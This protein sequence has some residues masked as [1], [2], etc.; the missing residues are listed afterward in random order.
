MKRW[1]K[2]AGMTYQPRVA[3]ATGSMRAW[4]PILELRTWK[5]AEK[6]FPFLDSVIGSHASLGCCS[7]F[8]DG[9]DSSEGDDESVGVSGSMRMNRGESGG[10]KLASE[11]FRRA[12]SDLKYSASPTSPMFLMAM[13]YLVMIYIINSYEE[14]TVLWEEIEASFV[15]EVPKEE[16]KTKLLFNFEGGSTRNYELFYNM[17]WR[18]SIRVDSTLSTDITVLISLPDLLTRPLYV[19]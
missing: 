19:I 13:S 7:W 12:I 9:W 3:K 8:C 17:D 10:F 11:K 14:R 18:V 1:L 16:R 6:A 5:A 4:K 15:S 2:I